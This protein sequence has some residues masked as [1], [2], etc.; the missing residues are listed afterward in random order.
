LI[1][2]SGGN[3]D[4]SSKVFIKKRKANWEEDIVSKKLRGEDYLEHYKEWHL[5]RHIDFN[6]QWT[7]CYGTHGD[8]DILVKHYG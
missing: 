2:I 8:E 5:L 7:A 4:S 6:G 1:R 3:S